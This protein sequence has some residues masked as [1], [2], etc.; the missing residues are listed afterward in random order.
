ML[1]FPEKKEKK[2]FENIW[3]E[4]LQFPGKKREKYIKYSKIT[5]KIIKF[6]GIL[7]RFESIERDSDILTGIAAF[8]WKEEEKYVFENIKVSL[9][10]TVFP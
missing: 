9:V 10:C 8:S 5:H 4:L 7:L 1:N 2:I 6:I 3:Q